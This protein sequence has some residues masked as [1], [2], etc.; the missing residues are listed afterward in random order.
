[1]KKGDKIL[2]TAVLTTAIIGIMAVIV[3]SL[4]GNK[5]LIKQDS[6]TIYDGTVFIEK[7]FNLKH[8]TVEIKKGK[9]TVTKADCKNQ[10]C[11]NTGTISKK[12]ETIICLPNKVYIEIK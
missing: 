7:T 1:M 4:G 3:F 11:V 5:V 10:I 2:I 9:V 6:K 12:G 8:N